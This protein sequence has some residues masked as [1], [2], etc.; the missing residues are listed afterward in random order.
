MLRTKGGRCGV[1]ALSVTLLLL[2]TS[3]APT[4]RSLKQDDPPGPW[5]ARQERPEPREERY[6][7]RRDS[8]RSSY[9]ELD[10]RKGAVEIGLGIGLRKQDEEDLWGEADELFNYFALDLSAKPKYWPLELTTRITTGTVSDEPA[11]AAGFSEEVDRVD[12][13]EIDV[14]L[15]VPIDLG[16]GSR[17]HFGGGVAWVEVTV[18]EE[19]DFWFYDDVD[20]V[21][22]DGDLGWWAGGG[23]ALPLGGGHSLALD[24]RWTEV[25]VILEGL[26]VET[27]GWTFLVGWT[28][29]RSLP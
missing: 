25:D 13:L 18:S 9:D 4:T 12:L 7:E 21:D 5:G 15:R 20:E 26:E 27:D 8:R 28:W 1:P 11:F 2:G 17:V 10:Y 3:C 24:A 19:D 22:Q 29:R 16:G 6:D 14:G 23:L